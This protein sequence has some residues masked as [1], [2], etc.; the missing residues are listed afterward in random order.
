MCHRES[1]LSSETVEAFREC[2]LIAEELHSF[3]LAEALRD[4]G[5]ARQ[6]DLRDPSKARFIFDGIL[7]AINWTDRNAILLKIPNF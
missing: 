1:I 2:V 3:G 6:E 4:V 5:L 7:Q